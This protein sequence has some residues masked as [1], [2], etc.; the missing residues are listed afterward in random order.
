[1]GKQYDDTYNATVALIER[2]VTPTTTKIAETLGL[3]RNN[4]SGGVNL[5]GPRS[6]ARAD[7]LVDHGFEKGTNG[8]WQK[9][10]P[11]NSQAGV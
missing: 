5:N 2:G 1:M 8:R 11:R 3:T 4:R 10:A 7:A 9:F 6:Q